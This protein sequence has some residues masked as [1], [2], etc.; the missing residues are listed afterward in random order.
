VKR[1]T[2]AT[3][4]LALA[5][6]V[7]VGATITLHQL[8]RPP[9]ADEAEHLHVTWLLSQ[10]QR[11][12]RDFLED[13]SP[14]L[15]LVLAPLVPPSPTPTFPQLDVPR[16]LRSARLLMALFGALAAASVTLLAWR[17]ARRPSALVIGLACLV[18]SYWTWRLGIADVRNDPPALCLFWLGLVLI[19]VGNTHTVARALGLGLGAAL[20]AISF[21][22]NP[23]WPIT[24]LVAGLFFLVELSRLL[25]RS[26]GRAAMALAAALAPVALVVAAIARL[27]SLRDVWFFTFTLN[28]RVFAWYRSSRFIRSFFH[29]PFEHASDPFKRALPAAAVAFLALALFWPRARAAWSGLDRRAA[30]AVLG[31]VVAAFLDIRLTPSYPNL[32]AQYYMMWS[33]AV[34]LVYACLPGAALAVL[35]AWSRPAARVAGPLVDL[36]AIGAAVWL[37]VH[38]ASWRLVR[39]ETREYWAAMGQIQRGLGPGDR[40]W[41]DS[42]AHPIGARDASY[43]WYA[44]GDFVPSALEQ[45]A[46]GAARA[47]LPPGRDAD[48]PICRALRGEDVH[49]RFISEASTLVELPQSRRCFVELDRAGRLEPTRLPGVLRVKK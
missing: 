19:V 6:L 31:V 41:I 4:G 18:G 43:Y 25:R 34:T 33:F 42:R 32:L 36:A 10:G 39:P 30:G 48:L 28:L 35:G 3:A 11:I 21:I 27:A 13:H 2:L 17:V 14:V 38:S 23:K 8:D 22:G 20:V 29:V 46:L 44:F 40:V 45:V 5:A 24:T 15:E 47:Y 16:F 9:H 12:Y 7:A 49:V 26:P 37:C 1:L